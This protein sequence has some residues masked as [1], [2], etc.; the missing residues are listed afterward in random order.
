VEPTIIENAAI[1]IAGRLDASGA[2]GYKFLGAELRERVTRFLPGTM[3]LDQPLVPAP[4]PLRFPFPSYATNVAD[5]ATRSADL[6]DHRAL[7]DLSD[8][9]R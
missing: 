8:E 1:K 7:A 4:I 3:V 2:E 5:D 9:I 6:D